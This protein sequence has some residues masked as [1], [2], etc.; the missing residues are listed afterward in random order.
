MARAPAGQECRFESSLRWEADTL[1]IVERAM[2]IQ[3]ESHV[4]GR[5]ATR[6]RLLRRNMWSLRDK[7]DEAILVWLCQHSLTW[8][9]SS[10]APD[11]KPGL[12]SASLTSSWPGL[13]RP[14]VVAPC[15]YGWPGLSRPDGTGGHSGRLAGSR[16]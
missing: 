16:V 6:Y 11:T 10:R 14:S 3:P 13:S 5:A 2:D 8:I 12:L 9:A 4:R 15:R 1:E 7:N